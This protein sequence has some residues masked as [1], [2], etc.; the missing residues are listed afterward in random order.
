[1]EKLNITSTQNTPEII[2]SPDEY[3]YSISGISAPEDVRAIYYPVLE[4]T[5]KFI[6][7]IS[8]G[9]IVFTP[10]NPLILKISLLYFNSSSA[11]FLYDIFLELRKLEADGTPVRIEWHYPV[12]DT[13]MKEAGTDIASIAEME[14][15]YIEDKA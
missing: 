12:G 1:M 3:V 4:W 9:K 7:E 5:R 13:D 15:I 11:K 14:F 8:L 6:G 10:T 2:M